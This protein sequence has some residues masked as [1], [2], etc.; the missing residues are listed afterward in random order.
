M[1]DKKIITID[2]L[3]LL[4]K[5]MKTCPPTAMNGGEHAR[6]HLERFCNEGLGITG[7]QLRE[8]VEMPK[9]CGC[10]GGMDVYTHM[11]EN[12]DSQNIDRL[13]V[14]RYFSGQIHAEKILEAAKKENFSHE[15]ALKVVYG[16]LLVPVVIANVEK[17]IVGDRNN[18][19]S[20]GVLKFSDDD[21]SNGQHAL[22]HYGFLVDTC[23]AE[24]AEIIAKYNADSELFIEASKILDAGMDFQKMHYHSRSVKMAG[25]L[26][27]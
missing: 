14:A 15:Y 21:F 22:M 25:E 9:D 20:S 4:R 18:V 8:I 1:I 19:V 13:A 5:I 7:C 10:E 12:T 3:D 26:K 17:G 27:I 16:H 23:S 6:M 2:G 11:L 24:E